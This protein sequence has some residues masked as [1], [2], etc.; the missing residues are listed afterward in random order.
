MKKIVFGIFAFFCFFN[1]AFSQEFNWW[2]TIEEYT[3]NSESV[4]VNKIG[5][6]M[7]NKDSLD[8]LICLFKYDIELNPNAWDAPEDIYCIYQFEDFSNYNNGG[9]F[10]NTV[11]LDNQ[12][13]SNNLGFAYTDEQKIC[14]LISDENRQIHV[15][16]VL[17]IGY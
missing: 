7:F 15:R 13:L 16:I 8:I 2:C 5:M 3:V 1:N 9:Q 14:H 12:V 17:T 4:P 6:L 10:Y 11:K